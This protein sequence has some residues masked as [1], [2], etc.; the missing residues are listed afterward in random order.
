MLGGLIQ[1]VR[2]P[3]SDFTLKTSESKVFRAHAQLTCIEIKRATST[4]K[5]SCPVTASV[6]PRLCAS[7]CT[8]F[9]DSRLSSASQNYN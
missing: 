1:F 7:G 2:V 9:P 6:E 3:R 8:V 4:A 5:Y